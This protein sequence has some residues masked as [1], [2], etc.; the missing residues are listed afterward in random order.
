MNGT[1]TRPKNVQCPSVA[2]G[3]LAASATGKYIILDLPSSEG[4]TATA[5]PAGK[6]GYFTQIS[7]KAGSTI[8]GAG[9]IFLFITDGTVDVE[10]F[11]GGDAQDYLDT[12]N[13]AVAVYEPTIPIL[14]ADAGLVFFA[15]SYNIETG[16]FVAKYAKVL[17]VVGEAGVDVD[18]LSFH[19][20]VSMDGN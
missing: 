9:N 4:G 14:V 6:N 15:K 11:F 18:S 10:P 2:D 16:P 20:G 3:P 12:T 7:I 19:I 13:G 8:G 17:W 5:F 1:I